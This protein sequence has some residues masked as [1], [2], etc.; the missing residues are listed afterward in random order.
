MAFGRALTVTRVAT[1]FRGSLNDQAHLDPRRKRVGENDTRTVLRYVPAT[2]R[3]TRAA[4]RSIS[5]L[6]CNFIF[7]S[8]TSSTRASELR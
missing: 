3:W 8:F 6:Q 2:A 4:M 1:P 5:S 7:L